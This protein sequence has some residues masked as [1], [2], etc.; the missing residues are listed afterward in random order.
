MFRIL[1]VD[2]DETIRSVM[3]M[4]LRRAGYQVDTAKDGEEAIRKS[5]IEFY[6]L[7]LIDIRLPD[8]EGTKLLSL[9]RETTPKMMKVIVTG[10]PVLDNALEAISRGVD[11]YLT[12]PVSPEKLLAI[13]AELLRKQQYESQF[14]Q[15]N[16]RA[17]VASRLKEARANR[18]E[19]A[20][21]ETP[22]ARA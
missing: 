22:T 1:I 8:M 9:M 7:A 11:G 17:Y 4:V 20:G 15:E 10:F 6:N 2:D 5:N 13:V 16:L 12:K 14:T 21:T 19:L 3:A 18:R